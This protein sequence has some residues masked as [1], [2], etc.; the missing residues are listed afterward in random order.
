MMY[1]TDVPAQVVVE[2]GG[3]GLS[4]HAALAVGWDDEPGPGRPVPGC[5]CAR[6]A[7]YAADGSYDDAFHAAELA[8]HLAALPPNLRAEALDMARRERARMG[9]EPD[10]CVVRD[11]VLL[12]LAKRA[13]GALRRPLDPTDEDADSESDDDRAELPVERARRVPIRE[14]ARRLGLGSP[15]QRGSD[16]AVTCPLHPDENPSLTLSP[17]PGLWY[18][19]PCG[20]GGDGIRLVEKTMNLGFA[21]A[22]RWLVDGRTTTSRDPAQQTMGAKP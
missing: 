19:F 17:D 15:K 16:L 13:P 11:G 7:A 21:E 22:V 5:G 10:P 3:D 6:C 2:W 18:C 1:E 4:E 8:T 12:E 20:E 14:V 9:L